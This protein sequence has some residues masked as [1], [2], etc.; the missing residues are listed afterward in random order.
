MIRLVFL[1]TFYMGLAYGSRRSDLFMTHGADMVHEP[2]PPLLLGTCE[3]L[4]APNGYPCKEYQVTTED[5]YILS[6]QNIPG[7]RSVGG[8][9]GG[10]RQP[11]LLQHGILM[12]GMTWLLDNPDQSL[13]YILADSGFDVWIANTRGTRWSIKHQF[14]GLGHG[15]N[16]WSMNSLPLLGLCIVKQGRKCIMHIP[17]FN[18]KGKVVADFLNKLCSKHGIDCYDLMSLFTGKNCCL[19][20]STVDLFLKYE[21]QPT[22]TKNMVHL[23]QMVR[24]GVLTKFDYGSPEANTVHYSQLKPPLYNMSNIPSNLPLFLSYGGQDALSDVKDIQLLLDNLKFHDADKLTVQFLKDFAHA[25]FVM[26]V[27]A[28]IIVY[29]PIIAFFNSQ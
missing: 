16:W 15:T 22:S 19:N 28:K 13:G 5:G 3:S 14:T 6:M 29:N 27:N 25:D 18:P 20:S 1:A 7:G 4:V 17:E 26:G 8:S 23:A 9:E 21:P 10:R 12:D 24:K 2:S 11:V